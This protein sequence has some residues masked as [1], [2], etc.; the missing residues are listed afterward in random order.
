MEHEAAVRTFWER[1]ELCERG[2]AARMP[3]F[4]ISLGGHMF[5]RVTVPSVNVP[6]EAEAWA[7]AWASTEQRREEIRQLDEDLSALRSCN[8]AATQ[9]HRITGRLQAIRAAKMRGVR[10]EAIK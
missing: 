9:R 7:A 5:T 1:A 10:P 8:I 3:S 4:C 6:T 2:G